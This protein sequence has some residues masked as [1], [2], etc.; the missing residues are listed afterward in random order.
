MKLIPTT[1]NPVTIT[2][3]RGIPFDNNYSEHTLL[4]TQF[5][6]H[7]YSGVGQIDL[8]RVVG[9]NKENFINMLDTNGQYVYPRT[10]KTGTYNFAFGNG[11]VTSVVME[12]TGDEINSNYMKVTSGSD[13]YYY[14]ITG[15]LQKNDVTYL[16]NLELDVFMTYSEE[17]LTNIKDKPVL[18]ERKH[19]R[20]LVRTK[21]R[22][23]NVIDHINMSCF[24]QETT[25]NNIKANITKNTIKLQFVDYINGND[26]FNDV[27]SNIKW[28]YI[29]MGKSGEDQIPV[30]DENGI[31]YPY[32]VVCFPATDFTMNISSH[33]YNV[34]M[35]D[36]IN[37]W[38][39]NP[40][41]QKIILSPFPPFKLC[42][43]FTFTNTTGVVWNVGTATGTAI[44][45]YEFFSDVL[46]YGTYFKTF[47][48]ISTDLFG[49]FYIKHGYGGKY[50]YSAIENCFDIA[51]NPNIG[52]SR[53]VNEFKLQIAPIK[54]YK[55]S[56]Y[57]G[58][59]YSIP[60]QLLFRI[61]SGSENYNKLRPFSIANT[62]PDNNTYFNYCDLGNSELDSKRGISNV[63][64][65]NYPTSSSAEQIYLSSQQ[66]QYELSR[67]MAGFNGL[68][69]VGAGILGAST[70]E[71]P[72]AISSGV[73]NIYGG[74]INGVLGS[75]LSYYTKMQDLANT[76]NSYNF[77]GSS[78][79][80]DTAF[81]LNGIGEGSMLPYIIRYGVDDIT[82]DM[83][84]EFLYHY[85]Y[86]YH[87]ECFFS[88]DIYTGTDEIFERKLF[89][90]VKINEDITVKLVGTNLP[91]VVAKKI[92]DVL[93]AGIKFW[94]FLDIDLT[95]PNI[96][97]DILKNYFQKSKYC[98]AEL[99]SVS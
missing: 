37:R 61:Y 48:D 30:Y 84:G 92:N 13:N 16:L 59:E 27:L 76:P 43:N 99:M 71:S 80:F 86:E 7:G 12:L 28:F 18:V 55:M 93:N 47:G 97:D 91:L 15:V 4:S 22:T 10:T 68:M 53:D 75:Y 14:F 72:G 45:N 54:E 94:S 56:A 44:G 78:L 8:D 29:I 90:Y 63:V 19:A 96:A 79:S 1:I 82:Y 85:G 88:T 73:M 67:W 66:N 3:Y 87:K 36:V 52:G 65:Y 89:N 25:F 70:G 5:K 50:Q 57:Y 23:D 35:D 46:L 77:A 62:N 60:T 32:G 64:T 81:S 9:Q 51:T 17:F 33:S 42:D 98:N 20:R 34:K 38:I 83:A 49:G 6:F 26:D 69:Q 24:N 31:T 21:N 74:A 58:G 41:I 39:G 95:N 40:H 11:L 2:L